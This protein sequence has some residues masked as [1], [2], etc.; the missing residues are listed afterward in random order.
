[1]ALK[2]QPVANKTSS[3]TEYT[4]LPEGEH[5]GRLTYVADLG[6]QERKY[7][8]DVQ[9]PC[10][11]ISLGIEII[12]QTTTIDGSEVPRL[13]WSKP[14]NLFQTM[15][16]KGSEY[17]IYKQFNSSAKVGTIADWES[18]I[19]LPCNVVVKHNVRGDR[20][21]D[22]VN[23]INAIPTKYR[24]KVADGV[25]TDGCVGDV[26]DEENPAQK[27]M[28]GLPR[29]KF[30]RRLLCGLPLKSTDTKL[31]SVPTPNDEKFDK[32]IPF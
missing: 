21:Y 29:W 16:E 2:R 1:M 13:L 8:G 31:R 20:T 17:L 30:E 19:G 10:Q 12:G 11:Q 7:E 15:T 23:S 5:E 9:P 32:D 25:L 6:V 22:D 27:A 18:V 24:D 28:Y 14:I 26:D 3:N 4:N